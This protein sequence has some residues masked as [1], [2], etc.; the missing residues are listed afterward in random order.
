[1]I[2]NRGNR[3]REV[4]ERLFILNPVFP[5]NLLFDIGPCVESDRPD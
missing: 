5:S 1:M 2:A 3:E 4:D